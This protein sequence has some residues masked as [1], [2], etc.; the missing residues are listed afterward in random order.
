MARLPDENK[1]LLWEVLEKQR[2]W[3]E[4]RSGKKSRFIHN[5]RQGSLL[6]IDAEEVEEVVGP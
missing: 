3:T 5:G 2:F 6:K 1:T 4:N